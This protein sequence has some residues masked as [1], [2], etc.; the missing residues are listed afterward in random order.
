MS[1]EEV[2]ASNRLKR[3]AREITG[4]TPT[5]ES[6]DRHEVK[7]AKAAAVAVAEERDNQ[8][9]GGD[10]IAVKPTKKQ[11]K[12]PKV[13]LLNRS[14]ETR[15]NSRYASDEGSSPTELAFKAPFPPGDSLPS[16]R[17]GTPVTAANRPT[18]KQKTGSGLRVKTS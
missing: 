16:S 18:R 9:D 2:D 8:S 7:T 1:Q 15:Q 17:A 6:N 3:K 14:R 11:K 5:T 10:S 12:I 13:R 4:K